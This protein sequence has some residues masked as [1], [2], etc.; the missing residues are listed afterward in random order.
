MNMKLGSFLFVLLFSVLII[1]QENDQPKEMLLRCDDI[2]MSHS[3]NMAAAKLI[4][5]NIPFSASVMFTCPW[6]QEAVDML[7]NA[8]HVAV[9]IHLTLNAEWKNYRWGPVLGKEA[10]PSLVDEN[11]FFFPSRSKLYENDPKVEEVAK[12]LR[13]Q[14]ERALNSGLEITYLDYHMGTAVDKP[15]YRAIVEKLAEEYKLGISR[16]FEEVDSEMMYDDPIES[17]TDSLEKYL[18]HLKSD[19]LNLFVAHI[20]VDNPE[21]QAM[22]D[23]NPFG[24]AEMSKHRQAE[25]NGLLS[26]VFKEGIKKNNIKMLTYKD[27]VER[28]GLQNMKSPVDPHGYK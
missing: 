1:S 20:T 23:L 18:T 24:P 5:T 13:A 10:V 15:E 17:K 12:E 9:G 21:M 8:H 22:I 28:V 19:T 27:I 4:E 3:V 26:P 6:Y 11:G 7:K 25:L 16:Y 2:G 14:I